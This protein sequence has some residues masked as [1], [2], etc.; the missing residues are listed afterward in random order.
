MGE[1]GGGLQ[2]V[3]LRSGSRARNRMATAPG[4]AAGTMASLN[5]SGTGAR[6]GVCSLVEYIRLSALSQHP[7][8]PWCW[9]M[10]LLQGGATQLCAPISAERQNAYVLG[11]ERVCSQGFLCQGVKPSLTP[12]SR[13]RS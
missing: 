9:R 7:C 1:G 5:A 6:V 10:K 3:R 8:V 12:R 4:W 2:C 13:M 11:V